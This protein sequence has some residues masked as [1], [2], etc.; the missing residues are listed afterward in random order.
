[1]KIDNLLFSLTFILTCE[2]EAS[3]L[4]YTK[5]TWQGVEPSLTKEI[6]PPVPNPF[7][8]MVS[9]KTL[10]RIGQIVIETLYIPQKKTKKYTRAR[11]D[12]FLMNDD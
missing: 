7:S 12:F 10:E 6:S 2:K 4:L 9:S 8:T 11:P 3:G 5:T 1:M